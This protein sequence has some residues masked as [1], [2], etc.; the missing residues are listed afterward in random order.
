MT[1]QTKTELPVVD[2]EATAKAL[3]DLPLHRA[4]IH[5]A[6]LSWL[7]FKLQVKMWMRDLLDINTELQAIREVILGSVGQEQK[8]RIANDMTI[9]KLTQQITVQNNNMSKVVKVC[10]EA[11]LRL[12]FYEKHVLPLSN[13]KARYDR[14]TREKRID[15]SRKASAVKE[16]MKADGMIPPAAPRDPAEGGHLEAPIKSQIRVNAEADPA[17]APYCMNPIHSSNVRM[18]LVEPFLWQCKCGTEHDERT[19]PPTEPKQGP[20]IP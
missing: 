14:E 2:L 19:T 20:R 4:F 12:E 5:R 18:E 15:E 17:Y 9:V 11:V 10:E 3:Q 16:K 1:D 8:Q 7:L 6:R 13:A